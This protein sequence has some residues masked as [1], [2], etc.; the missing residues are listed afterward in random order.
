MCTCECKCSRRPEGGVGSLGTVVTDSC[1]L[2]D[3]HVVTRLGLSAGAAHAFHHSTISL[4]PR[5]WA[6]LTEPENYR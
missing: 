1:G 4:A 2:S 3:V 5:D 6:S